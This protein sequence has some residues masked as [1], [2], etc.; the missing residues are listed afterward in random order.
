MALKRK[1]GLAQVNYYPNF[2]LKNHFS[3]HLDFNFPLYFQI[4]M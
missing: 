4:T 3:P 1:K 2:I